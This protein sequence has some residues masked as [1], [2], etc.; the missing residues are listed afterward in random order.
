MA[1]Y[2]SKK[3]GGKSVLGIHVA[4]GKFGEITGGWDNEVLLYFW[5]AASY[6]PFQYE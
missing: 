5:I 3:H 2:Q 6:F 4:R 1:T